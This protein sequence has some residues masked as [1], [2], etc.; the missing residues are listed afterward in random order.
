MI[1]LRWPPRFQKLLIRF[2]PCGW[3]R[4]FLGP[5][6]NGGLV[7]PFHQAAH[8]SA[9]NA[10]QH[11]RFHGL[12]A[13]PHRPR[14]KGVLGFAEHRDSEAAFS[15]LGLARRSQ[16]LYEEYGQKPP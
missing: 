11:I 5:M 8:D 1:D 6:D 7:A 2:L 13:A 4:G 12:L 3:L 14:P 10:G 15:R 9:V 16:D